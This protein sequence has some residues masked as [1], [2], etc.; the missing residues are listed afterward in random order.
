MTDPFSIAAGIITVVQA[1]S[2]AIKFIGEVK[3]SSH[4]CSKLLVE[5]SMTAGVL[6]SLRTLLEGESEKTWL[7]TAKSLAKPQG[8]L[9]EFESVVNALISKLKPA[10][11]FRRAGKAIAWPFKREEVKDILAKIE[12]QKTMFV[13]ALELD[14][15]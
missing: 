1:T 11:G 5:L 10:T 15:A 13:L 6:D 2:Y 8:P 7:A 3:D 14:H 12:R 9:K 4:E